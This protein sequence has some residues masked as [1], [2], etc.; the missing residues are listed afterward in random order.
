MQNTKENGQQM[1]WWKRLLFSRTLKEKNKSHKVAY[2]AVMTA[3]TVVVNALE[4]KFGGIQ[5]SL[6]IFIAAFAGLYLGAVSGF[7]CCFLG[8]MIGFFIHPFG[9]YSPWIGIATGLMAFLIALCLLLPK[10]KKYLSFYLI[11]GCL[12]IFIVCTCGITTLYLNKVWYKSMTYRECLVMRLFAQGQV[13]NSVVNSALT[14]VV[15]PLLVKVKP[16]RIIV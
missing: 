7:C 13:W 14:V 12:A 2:I 6:T 11:L 16:L 10:A 3:L 9:E 5:F 15:L 8:D 4:I 1:P